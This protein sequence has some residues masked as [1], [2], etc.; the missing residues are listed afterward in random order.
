M[1][2]EQEKIW[3]NLIGQERAKKLLGASLVRNQIV[4]NY[5]FEGPIGVGKFPFA[6][7]FARSL[8]CSSR[9]GILAC[10]QCADCRLFNVGTHPDVLVMSRESELSAD[11]AREVRDLVML[12]P[13]RAKGK[14]VVLN[15]IDRIN[16]SA[17]NI[18]LKTLEEAPGGS[19]FILTAHRPEKLLPTILSRSLR[20]PFYLMPISKL[21]DEY[22]NILRVDEKKAVMASELSGG[23]AGWGIRF[24][25]HPEFQELYSYGKSVISDVIVKLPLSAI[26]HKESV[27]LKFMDETNRIFSERED[28]K[29]MDGSYISRILDGESVNFHPVNLFVEET[30]KGQKHLE[31]LGLVLLGGIFRGMLLR[32]EIEGTP[33]RY[34]RLLESF[35]EA[36][37]LLERNLN[38]E[39]VLERFILHAHGR[40]EM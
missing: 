38:K 25:L 15:G 14:V 6:I 31:S 36:P 9:N 37:R 26:F 19:I 34:L 22:Q 13:Q 23:R 18:L 39:L 32:G 3:S 30:Q 10:N 11:E 2:Q 27:L 16:V 4:H 21:A 5:L 12:S 7:S 1:S 20:I 40:L 29:G 35:L 33:L 17:A 8:I 24:L 28:I